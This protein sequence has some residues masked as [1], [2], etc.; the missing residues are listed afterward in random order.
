MNSTELDRLFAAPISA[1]RTTMVHAWAC[2]R[3]GTQTKHEISKHVPPKWYNMVIQ[4]II[5]SCMATTTILVTN[6]TTLTDYLGLQ[7]Y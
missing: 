1:G 4:Y 3:L 6:R 2:L 5:P 7:H